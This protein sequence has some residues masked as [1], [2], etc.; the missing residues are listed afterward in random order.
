MGSIHSQSNFP[1]NP[2]PFEED[3]DEAFVEDSFDSRPKEGGRQGGRAKDDYQWRKW[4]KQYS[5]WMDGWRDGRPNEWTKGHG[6]GHRHGHGHGCGCGRSCTLMMIIN[7]GLCLLGLGTPFLPPI[8]MLVAYWRR[9]CTHLLTLDR[10]VCDQSFIL[11]HTCNTMITWWCRDSYSFKASVLPTPSLPTLTLTAS[12]AS[13]C[14]QLFFLSILQGFSLF[15]L[16]RKYIQ[17]NLCNN[18]RQSCNKCLIA[19]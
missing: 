10:G 1:R 5:A 6:H 14:V 17:Q 15:F 9:C 3:D 18:K 2:L 4:M 12:E 7:D 16:S 19:F 11:P 13:Y 8:A